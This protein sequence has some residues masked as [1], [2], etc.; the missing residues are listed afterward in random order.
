[1]YY[2]TYKS[3]GKV[4]V[5]ICLMFIFINVILFYFVL[6]SICNWFVFISCNFVLIIIMNIINSAL[7]LPPF[8]IYIFGAT[9]NQ[10][11]VH[12]GH[13]LK[14]SGAISVHFWM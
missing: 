8:Y 9:E 11:Y 5:Y 3:Y 4:V 10:L 13:T 7:S 14:L 12:L 2:L 6:S 1:M